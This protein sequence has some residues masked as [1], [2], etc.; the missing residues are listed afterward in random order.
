[1][2][3]KIPFEKLKKEV[4]KA[5]QAVMKSGQN[6]TLK[7]ILF[8]TEINSLVIRS[9][10]IDIG[11]ESVTMVEVV[12]E[13]EFS[14]L[15]DV[16][17]RLLNT[18]NPKLGTECVLEYLDNKLTI[19]VDTHTFT[20]KTTDCSGFPKLP[21]VEGEQFSIDCN[22]FLNGLKSCVFAV[23]KSDLKPEISGV[24]IYL[25]DDVITY[26]ATDAYRLCERKIKVEGR[27]FTESKFIVPEKNVKEIIRLFEEFEKHE[28][29]IV[30]SK[31]SLLL[32]VD[33][34]FVVSRLIEGNFPNYV[35]IIPTNPVSFAV[36]LKEDLVKSLKIVSFFG[37]KT[38]QINVLIE[39]DKCFLEAT[40]L[41]IGGTKE[42]VAT[43]LKGEGFSVKMNSKYLEEFLQIMGD[44]SVILKFTAQ[45]KAIIVQGLSDS[46]YTYLLMPSYR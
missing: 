28:L 24:Y 11:Y 7:S 41:D 37:D 39:K 25:K 15:G 10:N 33:N 40:S 46:S 21:N 12:T 5:A 9:T 42:E 19:S 45:N 2:K 43:T 1:M 16:I 8:K 31:N 35:Q 36:F 29:K 34:T 26:V 6:I 22:L 27:E 3:I 32:Q 4:N 44:Q 17:S 30:L 14:I 38:S 23:A 13:G 18:V 20:L